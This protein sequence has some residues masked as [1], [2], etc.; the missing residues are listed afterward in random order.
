MMVAPVD[1]AI[2][3]DTVMQPDILIAAP[4]AFS[5]TDLPEAPLLAIEIL[6]PST[7]RFDLI[8][9]RARYEAADCQHY[10]VT[11]PDEPRMIAWSLHDGAYVEVANAIGDDGFEVSDPVALRVRPV[12]L[13]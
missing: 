1:V 9:K 4:S 11:D 10:W 12:D 13:T 7:R 8:L 5:A 6:S 2:A 3:A